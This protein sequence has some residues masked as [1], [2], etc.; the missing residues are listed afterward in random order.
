MD[1]IARQKILNMTSNTFEI[2]SKR[3]NLSDSQVIDEDHVTRLRSSNGSSFGSLIQSEEDDEDSAFLS[4]NEETTTDLRAPLIGDKKR[5][6][7]KARNSSQYSTSSSRT[8]SRS[9]SRSS[10]IHGYGYHPRRTP[11]NSRIKPRETSLSDLTDDI[12]KE[13]EEVTYQRSN[14]SP[15]FTHT[16]I[17]H[18]SRL[19]RRRSAVTFQSTYKT[20]SVPPKIASV[21]PTINSLV[22]SVTPSVASI[23]SSSDASFYSD[24]GVLPR[25]FSGVHRRGNWSS[26]M[27]CL[28]QKKE[29]G[30]RLTPTQIL[31]RKSLE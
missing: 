4:E 12:I 30:V 27:L 2:Q 6:H 15:A 3:Q 8:S 16:K 29:N 23:G 13:N 9:S 25:S 11:R 24:L 5:A 31:I 26:F 17:E 28:Q 19:Q 18:K 7:K 20:L 14:S 1:V 10:S 21:C 22:A